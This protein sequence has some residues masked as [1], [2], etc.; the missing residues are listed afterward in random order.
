ME[1]ADARLAT[2]DDPTARNA[3]RKLQ[4]ELTAL[5]SVQLPDLP[6]VL[7]RLS[8]VETAVPNLP[9]TGMPAA[10]GVRTTPETE[11]PGALARAWRRIKQAARDLVA[12]RRIEPATAR[13][14]TEQEESLRRQHLE[15]QLFAARV[16]AMRP[17]GAAY[18]A[19][20]QS[21]STWTE[22][23]FD[24]STP[25]VSAALAEL[26]SLATVNIDPALPPVGEAGRM[27][28][29]VV[30]TAPA[31]SPTTPSAAP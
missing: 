17:D 25:E 7:A 3:R 19:A 27:L 1:A 15:L 4:E 14:V 11:P 9:V 21:A 8:Q 18:A 30:R 16:A 28:R 29:A 6:A 12:L 31:A 13:L 2:V 20:L 26:A 10:H 5:R 23:N 22:Q 24:A